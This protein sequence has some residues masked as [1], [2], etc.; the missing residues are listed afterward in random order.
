PSS[1]KTAG[2]DVGQFGSY[3]SAEIVHFNQAHATATILSA[4]DCG[5]APRRQSGQDRW[6]AR[7]GGLEV[8]WNLSRICSGLPIVVSRNCLAGG[9]VQVKSGI[10]QRIRDAKIAQARTKPLDQN[11]LRTRATNSKPGDGNAIAALYGHA[12]RK[13][14]RCWRLGLDS[15]SS[16]SA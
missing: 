9:I 5:K 16:S 7:I 3:S 10:L 6:F 15:D 14:S 2:R 13:I 4:Q 1:D 8:D 12:G 11:L